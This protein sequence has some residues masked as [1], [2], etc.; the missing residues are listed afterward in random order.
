[1]SKTA[2]YIP[3]CRNFLVWKDLVGVS[4]LGKSEIRYFHDVLLRVNKTVPARQ[5]PQRTEVMEDENKSKS[6]G[7]L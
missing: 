5:I 3:L 7:R 6:F 4:L 1:M 2:V